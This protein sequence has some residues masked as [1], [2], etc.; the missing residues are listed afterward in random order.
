MKALFLAVGF[1]ALSSCRTRKD[2]TSSVL[3]QPAKAAQNDNETLSCSNAVSGQ[4]FD[5]SFNPSWQKYQGE[6]K[7]RQHGLFTCEI[8]KSPLWKCAQLNT[9]FGTANQSIT[10]SN[11]GFFG[12]RAHHSDGR[13][14]TGVV[15]DCPK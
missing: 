4:T 6:L 13:T 14:P 1:L 8:G 11:D 12:V 9:G 15:L 3:S 5:I 7:G 2:D 10:V